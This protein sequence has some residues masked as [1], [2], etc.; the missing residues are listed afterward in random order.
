MNKE[1][2]NE[3]LSQLHYI[4]ELADDLLDLDLDNEIFRYRLTAN[5]TVKLITDLEAIEGACKCAV[6]VLRKPKI[7]QDKTK[8]D[9]CPKKHCHGG[10]HADMY[11]NR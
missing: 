3:L 4:K 5:N 7:A 8:C 11:C 6:E 10:L 1:N 2:R 9:D